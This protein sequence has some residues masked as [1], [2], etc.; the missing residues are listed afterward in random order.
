MDPLLR[1]FDNVMTQE[2]RRLKTKKTGVNL[3][4]TIPKAR[5]KGSGKTYILLLKKNLQGNPRLIRETEGT[6]HGVR[7]SGCPY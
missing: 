7:K 5:K 6:C 1:S 3:L 2:D 4:L